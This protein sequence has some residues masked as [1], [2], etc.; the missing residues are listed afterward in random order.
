MASM[1]PIPIISGATPHTALAMMRARGRS[2]KSSDSVFAGENHRSGAVT[3]RAGV[4]CRDRSAFGEGGLQRR[5]LLLRGVPSGTV[6]RRHCGS[7]VKGDVNEVPGEVSAG[8]RLDGALVA[9]QRKRVH[10]LA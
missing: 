9:P 5:E 4:S 6:I 3:K 1:G 7:I 8:L 10:V 2:S